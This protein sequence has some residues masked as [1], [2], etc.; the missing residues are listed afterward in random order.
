MMK[1]PSAVVVL[2]RSLQMSIESVQA[3]LHESTKTKNLVVVVV[4]VACCEFDVT[5]GGNS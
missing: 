1:K 4:V 5:S 2:I 3:F